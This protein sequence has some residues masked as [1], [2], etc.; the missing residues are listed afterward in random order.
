MGL[1]RF[2]S[3]SLVRGLVNWLRCYDRKVY[4]YMCVYYDVITH[5]SVSWLAE[6]LDY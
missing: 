2:L 5:G 1:R 6:G 4:I 3:I